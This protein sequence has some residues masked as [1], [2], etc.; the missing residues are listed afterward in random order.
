MNKQ[1]YV[2]VLSV[3]LLLT[4][5]C[6]AMGAAPV[7]QYAASEQAAVDVMYEVEV[8]G[9]FRDTAATEVTIERLVIRTA[10]MDLIVPT[11]EEAM[12]QV[13]DLVEELGGYIVSQNTY[14]YQDGVQA[15]ITLRVPSESF[16]TALD[17]LREMA[18]TVVHE[19]ISG[20]D[21]TEEYVDLDSRLRHLEAVEE[22]L[23][24]FL[25]EAEDTEAVLAVYEQLSYTQQEIEQVT[26]RM[27]YLRDQASMATIT[28]NLTPDALAQPL[29][30]SGWNLS[31][32]AR[33][34]LEVLLDILE[35]LVKG[36]IFVVI[37]V[38]PTLLILALPVAGGFFLVRW[39][40]RR[41]R[42]R[43]S[44]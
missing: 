41:Y 18:T 13:Q 3:V 27:E 37:A 39:I 11:T 26:G 17:E 28:V 12:A 43:R 40:V 6:G 25:E 24:E 8:A 20:Q 19:S 21:V 1:Q 34:A 44:K 2:V 35:G 42:A 7:P 4:V 38:L 23:L 5:G 31:G 10:S 16:D 36:L 30:V 33:E 22:Q 14:Q 29:E 15:D 32:T 9:A